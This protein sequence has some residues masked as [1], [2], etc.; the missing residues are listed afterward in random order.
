MPDTDEKKDEGSYDL[1]GAVEK[2]FRSDIPHF[3]GEYRALAEYI[4]FSSCQK[5]IISWA[6]TI[7]I[8]FLMFGAFLFLLSFF[9]SSC[10]ESTSLHIR[11]YGYEQ[12]ESEKQVETNTKKPNEE[13]GTPEKKTQSEE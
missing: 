10:S 13:T 2:K 1:I 6:V 12:S 7:C 3:F 11:K 5:K 8:P 4:Q 9:V